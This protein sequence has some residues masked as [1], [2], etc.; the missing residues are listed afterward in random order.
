MQRVVLLLL[1]YLA[2]PIFLTMK[3]WLPLVM[4]T[5]GDALARARLNVEVLVVFIPTLA[6]AGITLSLLYWRQAF[7]TRRGPAVIGLISG[8][9]ACLITYTQLPHPIVNP[10]PLLIGAPAMGLFCGLAFL[11][12]N[13]KLR[14]RRGE[15]PAPRQVFSLI[16]TTALPLWRRPLAWY[17]NSLRRHNAQRL[18]PRYRRLHQ[19][20]G[21]VSGLLAVAGVWATAVAITRSTGTDVLAYA[22]NGPQPLSAILGMVGFLLI[23]AV[24]FQITF[25]IIAAPALILAR[26]F[27]LVPAVSYARYLRDQEFPAE[28][29][30]EDAA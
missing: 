26:H 23:L 17:E 2:L 3:G 13:W 11:G 15:I 25:A 10:K 19:T 24:A 7:E 29:L 1:S 6:L 16:D 12:F 27:G 5:T 30:R 8:A 22:K 18:L 20:L 14:I 28:W 21:T 9:L 4:H